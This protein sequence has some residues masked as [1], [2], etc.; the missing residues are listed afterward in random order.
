MIGFQYRFEVLT[1]PLWFIRQGRTLGVHFPR[2]VFD[3][4]RASIVNCVGLDEKFVCLMGRHQ[5]C[6]AEAK[7]AM[8]ELGD[9]TRA[10]QAFA[11]IS[12]ISTL[13]Q[14]MMGDLDRHFYPP[15][16]HICTPGLDCL[17]NSMKPTHSANDFRAVQA[18]KNNSPHNHRSPLRSNLSKQCMQQANIRMSSSN[19]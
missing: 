11:K 10:C 7:V 15:H 5:K 17:L 1:A 19:P 6:E 8:N 4:S 3:F 9:A 16:C 2:C 14:G 18:T 13:F 12:G